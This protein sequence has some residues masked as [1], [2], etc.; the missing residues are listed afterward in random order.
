MLCAF[1]QQVL[2]G[3]TLVLQRLYH[4]L[5]LIGGHDES[6]APWNKAIVTES[7]FAK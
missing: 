4:G 3:Q 1:K 2:E 6:S 5:S 7:R